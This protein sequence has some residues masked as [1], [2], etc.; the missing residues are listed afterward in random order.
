MKTT[1]VGSVAL[2]VCTSLAVILYNDGYMKLE[3]LFDKLGITPGFNCMK[4]FH[5]RDRVRVYKCEYKASAKQKKIRQS[6]RRRRL[7][8]QDR[9]MEVEGV[10]Y[11]YGG[12]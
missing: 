1:F 7:E 4:E 8:E 10:L 5:R 3:S 2:K 11:E 6:D 12:F 9:N